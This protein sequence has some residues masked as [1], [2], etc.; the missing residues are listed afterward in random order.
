MKDI[1]IFIAGFVTGPIVIVAVLGAWATT[2][3]RKEFR[4]P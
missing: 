3:I 4:R 1:A 2:A